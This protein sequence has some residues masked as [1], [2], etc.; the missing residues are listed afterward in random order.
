MCPLFRKFRLFCLVF[1]LA[2][3][4]FL[5]EAFSFFLSKLYCTILPPSNMH[6]QR[7]PKQTRHI[8]L[9]RHIYC[10]SHTR[11]R[12]AQ[13]PERSELS[14]RSE[15]MYLNGFPMMI[16]GCC[17]LSSLKMVMKKTRHRKQQQCGFKSNMKKRSKEKIDYLFVKK[18][19]RFFDCT[20]NKYFLYI[21]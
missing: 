15:L 8:F 13:C 17:Q 2:H 20:A 7:V 6:K 10:S 4:V 14:I 16:I 1:I 9:T 12:I 3:F 5:K 21:L 19:F 18:H 11:C